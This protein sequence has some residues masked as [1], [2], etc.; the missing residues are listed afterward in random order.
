MPFERAEEE[1]GGRGGGRGGGSGRRMRWRRGRRK[2]GH[3]WRSDD[4]GGCASFLTPF[5]LSYPPHG[6]SF[7][8]MPDPT[9]EQVRGSL[10]TLCG[11]G[12]RMCGV[13]HCS[14]RIISLYLQHPSLKRPLNHD[15]VSKFV[16][17]LMVCVFGVGASL[18][19][20]L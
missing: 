8:C 11:L 7:V 10:P 5:V 1:G 19:R 3:R 4:P 9:R 16:E 2:K 13:R 20:T 17:G 6:L 12:G 15:W 14:F 18:R